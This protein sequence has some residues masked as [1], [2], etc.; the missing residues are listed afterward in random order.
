MPFAT[1][2]TLE[3]QV[4]EALDTVFKAWEQVVMCEKNRA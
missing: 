3:A 4:E 2:M 1:I